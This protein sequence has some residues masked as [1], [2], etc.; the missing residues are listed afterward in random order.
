RRLDDGP[1]VCPRRRADRSGYLQL[2]ASI[3]TDA[4]CTTGGRRTFGFAVAP[5]S[6]AGGGAGSFTSPV[7]STLWL[8]WLARSAA[9]WGTSKYI[10]AVPPSAL[11]RMRAVPPSVVFA[12]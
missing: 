4:T 7:T 10:L 12:C 11:F 9:A 6:A 8:T 5:S 3:F 1:A 2:S